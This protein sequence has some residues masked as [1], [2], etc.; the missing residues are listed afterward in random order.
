MFVLWFWLAIVGVLWLL[1]K[2]LYDYLML[3][4]TPSFKVKWNNILS[5][6]RST[7]AVWLRRKYKR[8]SCFS[9]FFCTVQE[10]QKNI[11]IDS[12]HLFSFTSIASFALLSDSAKVSIII[13]NCNFWAINNY[14]FQFGLNSAFFFYYSL[15]RDIKN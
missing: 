3:S 1:T 13:C 7:F 15:N 12:F 11:G 5:K 6:S 9:F 4:C 14:N 8:Q 10:K 2:L